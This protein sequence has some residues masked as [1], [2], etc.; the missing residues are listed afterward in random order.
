[1]YV[2]L[3]NPPS[4]GNGKR[5]KESYCRGFH[6][7]AEGFSKVYTMKLM[8]TF[9]DQTGL[10][11]FNLSRGVSF[12]SK[13]PF[14]TQYIGV[15]GWGD[16]IPSFCVEE[17]LKFLGH[18]LAPLDKFVGLCKIGRFIWDSGLRENRRGERTT[19]RSHLGESRVWRSCLWSGLPWGEKE[20]EMW[21]LSVLELIWR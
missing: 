14:Y 16:K 1:M 17:G 13:N 4:I 9:C 10:A 5:K 21:E 12:R 7:K 6:Y 11:P 3:S 20:V 19:E 2:Q 8:K 18:S 15:V